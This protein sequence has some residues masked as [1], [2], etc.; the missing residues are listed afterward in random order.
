RAAC[1]GINWR[2]SG[3][4]QMPVLGN[5]RHERFAQ[6]L[7]Q[8]KTATDAH[9]LAGYRRNDG[10]ASTLAQRPDIQVRLKAIKGHAAARAVVS[11][12]S[13]IDE[14]EQVRVCAMDS[15]QLNAANTAIK[16]KGVLSG[17]R[18]ERSE[19]GSPGEFDHL[20]DEELDRM[21]LERFLELCGPRLAITDG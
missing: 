5:P 1:G 8:G 20:T 6:L 21:L 10:N 17:V 14:A 7:A 19:I 11:V 3:I 4:A 15:R 16:E 18:I 2:H 13:L 12:E 9:E